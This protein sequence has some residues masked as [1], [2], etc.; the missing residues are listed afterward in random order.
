MSKSLGNIRTIRELLED[1]EPDVIR[2]YLISAHYR[3]PLELKDDSLDEA[4]SALQRIRNC[5]ELMSRLGA[6]EAEVAADQL[7]DAEKSLNNDVEDASRKFGEAMDDDFN[8]SGAIGAIFDLVASA[9]RFA[10][11][12]EELSDQGRAVLGRVRSALVELCQILGL[13]AVGESVPSADKSLVDDLM[14]LMIQIRKDARERKDWATADTIRDGLADIGV[15][16]EDTREGT[17]WKLE[18]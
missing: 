17:I 10:A 13:D 5:V 3:G 4:K 8:T 18:K 11:E 6:V 15:K 2:F 14:K 7:S 1:Y 16:L 12:N 9:N